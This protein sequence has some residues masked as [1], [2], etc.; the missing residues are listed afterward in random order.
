MFLKIGTG[1]GRP[2]PL[3]QPALVADTDAVGVAASGMR[4]GT[5][6]RPERLY[7]TVL[8][9]VKM[10]TCAGEAPAQVVCCQVVFRIAA[11]AAGGGTVND[12]EV[13]ESHF[14]L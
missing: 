11:V 13:D 3:V 12:D 10:I 4:T 7:I 14:E 8:T 5:F 2:S 6:Q 1:I 9:D